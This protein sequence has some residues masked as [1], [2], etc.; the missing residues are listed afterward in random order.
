VLTFV[1]PFFTFIST[2]FS[3]IH[4]VF[5]FASSVF[6]FVSN[7]FFFVNTVERCKHVKSRATTV[8]F[9]LGRLRRVSTYVQQMWGIIGHVTVEA[10]NTVGTDG[11]PPQ[12]CVF[13]RQHCAYIC[14]YLIY[15]CQYV[16]TF[17]GTVLFP[18]SVQCFPLSIVILCL[19]LSVLCFLTYWKSTWGKETQHK[20]ANT[21]G[22]LTRKYTYKCTNNI[23]FTVK[24][25]GVTSFII[26]SSTVHAVSSIP[27]EAWPLRA[28]M[29]SFFSSVKF[30]V[31][32]ENDSIIHGKQRGKNINQR[33]YFLCS[34]DLMINKEYWK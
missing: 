18:S 31:D 27:N 11:A 8:Y 1:C 30:N 22:T 5:S 10:G 21:R 14:L 19:P 2:V 29:S 25:L 12:Y 34:D 33:K 17:A 7:V 32:T 6:S 4:T 13:L 26:I 24:C 9:R 28:S 3:F 16:F 23:C 20:Q 15:F